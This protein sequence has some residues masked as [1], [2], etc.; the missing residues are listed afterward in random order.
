MSTEQ[1]TEQSQQQS[2]GEFERHMDYARPDPPDNE[3][4]AS[5]TTASGL[6]VKCRAQATA[7][8]GDIILICGDVLLQSGCKVI[9]QVVMLEALKRSG[10]SDRRAEVGPLGP[11]VA[12]S[13]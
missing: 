13:A 8:N 7:D 6:G 9:V 5:C 12:L 2:S 10:V 1:Q 11:E 3:V 4:V